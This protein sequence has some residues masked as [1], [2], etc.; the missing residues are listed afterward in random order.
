MLLVR[1]QTNKKIMNVS[2]MRDKI[3]IKSKLNKVYLGDLSLR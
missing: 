1:L 3:Q 2:K